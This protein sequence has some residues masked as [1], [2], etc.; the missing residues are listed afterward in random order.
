[1]LQAEVDVGNGLIRPAELDGE[2]GADGS[3][4]SVRTIHPQHHV[5]TTLLRG[6]FDGLAHFTIAIE[7]NPHDG[8]EVNRTFSGGIEERRERSMAYFKASC[9]DSPKP[10]CAARGTDGPSRM[11]RSGLTSKRTKCASTE[12]S[13][14]LS[15]YTAP[16]QM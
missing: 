2:I 15:M 14:T 7:H 9:N 5:M 4:T 10:P 13:T 3:S 8:T 11:L 1:M 12:A 6:L 16:R